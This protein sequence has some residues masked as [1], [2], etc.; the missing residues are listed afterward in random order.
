MRLPKVFNP[1]LLALLTVSCFSNQDNHQLELRSPDNQISLTFVLDNGKPFYRL[2][3]QQEKLLELSEMGLRLSADVDVSEGLE[4]AEV[5]NSTVN[6]TLAWPFGEQ[7]HFPQHYHEAE[8]RLNS[9]RIP[10]QQ[11]TITMRAYNEGVAFRYTFNGQDMPS[12]LQLLEEATTFR[13][14]APRTAYA[15]YGHEGAYEA[16]ALEKV[17][18]KCE[19]PLLTLTDQQ[20]VAINEA[21][22]ENFAR[23][24]LKAD[25]TAPNSLQVMFSSP[26][27]LDESFQTPWRVLQIAPDPG[28]LIEQNYLIHALAPE[29]RLEAQDWIMPGKAMRVVTPL[30]T[31]EES[32]KVVDFIA[33]NGL[34]Y[35]E[36]DAGWYGKGYGIPNESDPESDASSVVS[37]L[38]LP[39]VISYAR[40][41]GVG[42]ILYVNKVALEQQI[43]E[44][45]PLYKK[46]G[47][48]GLKFGFV[49]GRTQQGISRTHEW[50]QKA[51][52]HR[53]IVD[54][55]DNYRPTGMSRTYPNLLTQEGI[56]GNEHMPTAGHNTLLPYTRFISGAGDYTICYLNERLNTTSAHQLA[57]GVIYFSPLHFIYWYGK[58]EDFQLSQGKTFFRDLPTTWDES[59]V[60]EGKVGEYIV[61]GRR[62]GDEWFVGAITN[63]I[64]RSVS[65]PLHFLDTGRYQL[66]MYVDAAE[67]D[68]N[69]LRGVVSAGDSLQLKMLSAGGVAMRLVK[70]DSQAG[71]TSNV[72]MQPGGK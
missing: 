58:P 38:N 35:A 25:N 64:E 12:G 1:L 39:E 66:S 56:R 34:D 5:T 30:F 49:D 37:G 11:L 55:H 48:V 22:L 61:M 41:Q 52:D 65:L 63:E 72:D 31:T 7:S 23:M 19:L 59:R 69:E 62:K 10:Q 13:F 36:F 16:V 9:K 40:E 60:L 20:A 70:S 29:S 33:R 8:I 28:K 42:T 21:G 45:L 3:Y 6:D 17:Q 57:L 18:E 47:V 32:K 43:D 24:F 2:D 4:L 44:I 26:I 27:R 54:I 71:K 67:A 46:W 53:M 50:V 68:V 15:E 51:A 14:A